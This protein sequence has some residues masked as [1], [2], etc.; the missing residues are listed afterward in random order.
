[1]FSTIVGG[2]LFFLFELSNNL[3]TRLWAQAEMPEL[4]EQIDSLTGIS[5]T[6][7]APLGKL[8]D[9]P[10]LPMVFD[11]DCA[12]DGPIDDERW[13][14]TSDAL[15]EAQLVP[16]SGDRERGDERE[17]CNCLSLLPQ[18]MARI[19]ARGKT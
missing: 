11:A 13:R 16:A 12:D 9:L 14:Y 2:P 18:A 19:S 1:L 4:L 17:P 15:Q 7:P 10:S 6:Q 3:E 8:D 5:P